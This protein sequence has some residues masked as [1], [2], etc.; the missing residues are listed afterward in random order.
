MFSTAALSGLVEHGVHVGSTRHTTAS[1][2][3][4]LCLGR[5]PPPMNLLCLG[6]WA[7]MSAQ[8]Q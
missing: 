7:G 2:S 5:L 4:F 6:T 1:L 8:R 3:V